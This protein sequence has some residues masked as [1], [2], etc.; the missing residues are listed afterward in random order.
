MDVVAEYAHCGYASYESSGNVGYYRSK[1][2]EQLAPMRSIGVEAEENGES[3]GQILDEHEPQRF[4]KQVAELECWNIK[5][6]ARVLY[7]KRIF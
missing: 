3:E 5:E 6:L 7:C 2:L 4:Q 1:M